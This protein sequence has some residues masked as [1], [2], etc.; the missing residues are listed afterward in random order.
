VLIFAHPWLENPFTLSAFAQASQNLN[1]SHDFARIS[2]F[3]PA[4][5]A[6]FTR[7]APARCGNALERL[8]LLRYNSPMTLKAIVHIAEEGGFWAEVPAL[9]GCLTQAETLDELKA[10]LHEA[11]ELWLSVDDEVTESNASDKVLELTV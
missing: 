11:I 3:P 8:L 6:D 1:C 5:V 10:N 4:P 7:A 9:P 2:R